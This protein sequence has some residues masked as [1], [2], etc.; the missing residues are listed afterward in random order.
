MARSQKRQKRLSRND[1]LSLAI[2]V[3]A[4]EGEAELRIDRLCKKLGVTKGSFYAHFEDR[5]DF[6]RQIVAYWAEH[7]TKAAIDEIDNLDVETPEQRLLALMQLLR[8]NRMAAYDLVVRA[9]A[10]HDPVVAQG[11]REVDRLRFNYAQWMFH[12]MGFSGDEL[13]LRTRLFLTYHSAEPSMRFPPSELSAEEE[14]KLRH[15][16]LCRK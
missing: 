4:N 13:D 15:A 7:L 9:W 6:I 14:L 10:T 5:A 3:L 16:F 12:E 8:R 2:R 1:W 11:V